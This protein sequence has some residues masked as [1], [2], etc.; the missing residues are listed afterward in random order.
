M[1]KWF[2]L[3]SVLLALACG[4]LGFVIADRMGEAAAAPAAAGFRGAGDALV[5]YQDDSTKAHYAVILRDNKLWQ[6]QLGGS[7]SDSPQVRLKD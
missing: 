2:D 6:V 5:V 7:S 4:A 3:R 1:S